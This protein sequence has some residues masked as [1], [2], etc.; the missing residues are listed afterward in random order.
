MT[1]R[2]IEGRVW[3]WTVE[4]GD[5]RGDRA[6][7]Q[8]RPDGLLLWKVRDSNR[9]ASGGLGASQSATDYLT[10]GCNCPQADPPAAVLLQLGQ[11]LRN[12]RYGA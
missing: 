1:A 3:R 7:L 2:P 9:F 10:R 11:A 5:L 4:S 8:L 6:S 12:A